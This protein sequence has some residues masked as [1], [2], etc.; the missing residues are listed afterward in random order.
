MPLYI[1]S[2]CSSWTEK[3]ALTPCSLCGMSGTAGNC[4]CFPFQNVTFQI[5]AEGRWRKRKYRFYSAK[6]RLQGVLE[7]AVLS[8]RIAGIN[9]QTEKHVF[10]GRN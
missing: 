3:T 1:L 4:G 10:A 9:Q 7:Q 2:I 8:G 5:V 6:N